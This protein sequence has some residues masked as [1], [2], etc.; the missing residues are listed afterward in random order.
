MA[1][2]LAFVRPHAA[3]HA[4]GPYEEVRFW[5]EQVIADGEV[6]AHYVDSRWQ[7][8]GVAERFSSVEF[9]DRVEIHFAKRNGE[10]SRRFGPYR[11]FRLMDG[12]AYENEHVFA[13]FDR[14]H[15]DWYSHSLGIHWPMMAVLAATE[16]P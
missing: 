16:A 14:Q 4:C 13:S 3:P 9:R 2:H 8:E 7:L 10:R 6:L 12:I 11:A 15:E 5:R 1:L